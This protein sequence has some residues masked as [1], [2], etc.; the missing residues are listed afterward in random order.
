MPLDVSPSVAFLR[1]RDQQP[2]QC[3][4]EKS[5]RCG[6][7]EAIRKSSVAEKLREQLERHSPTGHTESPD[8]LY[9]AVY[10]GHVVT[11]NSRIL[12]QSKGPMQH[13]LGLA[14]KGGIDR[15]PLAPFRHEAADDA[16]RERKNR[17]EESQTKIEKPK[18]KMRA[19]S[20]RLGLRFSF[21]HLWFASHAYLAQP[22]SE[23]SAS[24]LTA[25]GSNRP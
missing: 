18:R 2:E 6:K 19:G 17:R 5:H 11:E 22:L 16:D 12:A 24:I 4:D 7:R 25:H 10:P 23:Y 21:A 9:A 13:R 1:E 14:T 20:V 15:I 8:L 3:I